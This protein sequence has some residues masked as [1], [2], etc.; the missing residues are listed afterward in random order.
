MKSRQGTIVAHPARRQ[1]SGPLTTMV[2]VNAMQVQ[3]NMR[4]LASRGRSR[5]VVQPTAA[6]M[7]PMIRKRSGMLPSP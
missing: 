6:M 5:R 4:A 7:P 1:Y 2:R 3:K